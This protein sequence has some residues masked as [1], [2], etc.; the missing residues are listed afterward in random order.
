MKNNILVF[1]G[2]DLQLSLIKKILKRDFNP[3]V[4]DPD[5]NAT[6]RKHVKN[7]YKVSVDDYEKTLKLTKKYSAIG[8][9]T[10]AT[11]KPLRMMARIAEDLSLKFPSFNSIDILSDKSKLKEL[12]ILNN[13]PCAKGK[14]IN[15]NN[16]KNYLS[17][18]PLKFPLV[19][20]PVDNS[21]SRGVIFCSNQN[22]LI[23]N[24]EYTKYY[25]KKNYLLLEEYLDG[26]EI[27]VEGYI[28][29]GKINIIQY[30][31]KITNDLPFNVEI[32]HIQPSNISSKDKY[33]IEEILN[34]IVKYSGIDNCG[35]HP[36]FKITKNG[37]KIIEFGTRLGGDKI[38]SHLVTYST[39][40]DL[41]NIIIDIAI[42]K[43]PFVNRK[44]SFS[45]GIK[46]FNFNP[47]N[48]IKNNDLSF[49]KKF[50]HIKNYDISLKIND[51]PK[52]IKNSLDRYGYI[53]VAAEKRKNLE[54]YMNNIYTE[55]EKQIFY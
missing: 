43:T 12:L 29:D 25:T 32:G 50:K 41:E 34:N 20:K 27:S 40:V 46:Y 47:Q 38:T 4:I 26:N 5:A 45:S 7:F 1:G 39:G 6:A 18:E 44:K 24:L 19:L 28:C 14:L 42:G 9:V 13:I 33:L 49:L 11:E 48:K 21:G 2:G 30:T 16:T 22:E 36:E 15:I 51:Y 17:I 3:I 8:L 31:D 37:P 10:T 23:K 53:I 35:I 54:R 55:I 52:I